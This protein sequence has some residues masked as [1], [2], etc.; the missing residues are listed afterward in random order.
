MYKDVE[1]LPINGI[2]FSEILQN[3]IWKNKKAGYYPA[4]DLIYSFLNCL[5]LYFSLQEQI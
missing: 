4:K 3:N 5:A 1:M 2:K